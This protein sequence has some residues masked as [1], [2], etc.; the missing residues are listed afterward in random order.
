MGGFCFLAGTVIE[1]SYLMENFLKEKRKKKKV[2]YPAGGKMQCNIFLKKYG[3]I[4]IHVGIFFKKPR[5]A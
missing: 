1:C 3:R 5:R 2:H 4:F